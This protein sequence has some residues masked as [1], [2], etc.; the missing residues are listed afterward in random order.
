MI[1]II[2][3]IVLFL[4]LLLLGIPIA[5]AMGIPLLLY[6]GLN[7]GAVPV[8]MVSHTMVSP[9]VSFT[10]LAL[11]CFLLSGRLMNTAGVT[12]RLF[13]FS[14]A[15]VGRFRGGLAYAN[16][17]TSML[18]ASMSGTAVGD[19]GGLGAM[20]MK[21]MK[22]AGYK[23]DFA[24]GITAA[25]SILGPIIPPSAAMV[26][27]GSLSGISIGKL[28][29]AGIVPGIFL[30]VAMM[31]YIWFRGHFTEEGKEWPVYKMPIKDALKTVPRV[32]PA[33][34]SPVIII[35]GIMSGAVTPTEAAV[36]SINYSLI[37]GLFYK[38]INFKS[39]WETL[40]SAVETTGA[41][42]FIMSVASFFSWVLTREGLPQ[43]IQSG[44]G[45]LLAHGQIVVMLVVTGVLLIIGCFLDTSAACILITPILMPIITSLGI[46][47][48]YFGVVMIIALMMGIIT[49]PFGICLFVVSDVAKIS[50]KSVTKEAVRYIPA[51]VFTTIMLILFPQIITWLPNIMK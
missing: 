9:L 28:F 25:S 26:L 31:A 29:I 33:M 51:M 36:M 2:I 24:A 38:K 32:I 48:V 4:V 50:V 42:L 15:V 44:L 37:L 30:A 23:T 7:I 22:D 46:D 3:I 8:T 14:L 40:E 13:D 17:L 39:I 10:L 6:L 12:D 45:G 43:L 20:E 34:I 21:M 49:P 19:A 47:P 1:N 18:F 5:Y 27:L 11:P 41:F 35:A 16:C